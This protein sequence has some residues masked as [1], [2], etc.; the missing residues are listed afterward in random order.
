VGDNHVNCGEENAGFKF[1]LRRM[2]TNNDPIEFSSLVAT[3]FVDFSS[4]RVGL[5]ISAC[6]EK[7]ECKCT[8]CQ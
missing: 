6:K 1:M 2:M 4:E 3:E 8:P 7:H 5:E